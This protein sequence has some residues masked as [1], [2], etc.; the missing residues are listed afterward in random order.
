MADC[1][2]DYAEVE[3]CSLKRSGERGTGGDGDREV[4]G[5]EK[6]DWREEEGRGE[7]EEG[8]EKRGEE[9]IYR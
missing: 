8:G 9:R 1:I 5:M 6:D 4:R 2:L 3:K 7:G